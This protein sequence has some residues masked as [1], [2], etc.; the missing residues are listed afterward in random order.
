MNKI[1]SEFIVKAPIDQA[2]ERVFAAR[3]QFLD[4]F[5]P[6]HRAAFLTIGVAPIA[7]P[8]QIVVIMRAAIRPAGEM[9]DRCP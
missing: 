6:L 3:N 9:F 4:F 7:S 5:E 8:S 1:S 2:G